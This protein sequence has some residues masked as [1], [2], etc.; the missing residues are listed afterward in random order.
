MTTLIDGSYSYLYT[1]R[2]LVSH[3]KPREAAI[4]V[5]ITVICRFLVARNEQRLVGPV[6]DAIARLTINLDGM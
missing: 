5:I 4:E 3:G 6:V 2:A 1:I